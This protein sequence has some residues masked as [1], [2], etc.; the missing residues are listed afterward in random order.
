MEALVIIIAIA[1]TLVVILILIEIATILQIN[2][3]HQIHSLQGFDF[4]LN[5]TKVRIFLEAMVVVS[6]KDVSVFLAFPLPSIIF[7]H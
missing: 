2:H 1:K 6:C 5:H 7:Q 4:L 3:P